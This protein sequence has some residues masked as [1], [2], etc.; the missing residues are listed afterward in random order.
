MNE[1]DCL[2]WD[3]G[4]FAPDHLPAHGH[5]DLLGFEASLGG[6]LFLVDT[7]TFEYN[8]GPVR[9]AVRA[10]SSHNCMEI[11]GLNQCDVYSRFRLG[12][13][14]RVDGFRFG[15]YRNF[16]WATAS[17]NAYRTHSSQ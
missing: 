2:I 9:D 8:E 12:H 11:D 6:K 16:C 4:Q 13:R 17:H 3:A 1:S 5:S 14:G 10:T 15:D 7:G